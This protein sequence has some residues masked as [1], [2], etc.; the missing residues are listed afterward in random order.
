MH[1]DMKSQN[2]LLDDS[3]RA[4]VRAAAP[5]AAS[6]RCDWITH[7]CWVFGT[8]KVADFGLSRFLAE[9]KTRLMSVTNAG[10]GTPAWSAPEI[11]RA[12][13]GCVTAAADIWSF[14]VIIWEVLTGKVPWQGKQLNAIIIGIGPPHRPLI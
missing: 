4:K 10:A 13:E 11:L 8:K 2:V 12:E 1:R 9:G 5:A 6:R 3:G 7:S 14:G